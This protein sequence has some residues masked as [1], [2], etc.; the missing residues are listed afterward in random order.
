MIFV[1]FQRLI[2]FN[3]IG[4][5]S[6]SI[7]M[8]WYDIVQTPSL[9]PDSTYLN[10]SLCVGVVGGVWPSS[11]PPPV[12]WELI[13]SSNINI[14]AFLGSSL[15]NIILALNGCKRRHKSLNSRRSL[16]YSPSNACFK[17]V[18]AEIEDKL[19]LI[20]SLN[21]TMSRL[22]NTTFLINFDKR[23][24]W[25]TAY[26]TQYRLCQCQTKIR[27][28]TIIIISWVEDCEDIKDV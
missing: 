25:D 8:T 7:F 14:P 27:K 1:F 26:S 28:I 24:E 11:R 21:N 12:V 3:T 17:N 9:H 23:T 20:Y 4:T 5:F 18:L 2:F 19:N 22:V 16:G 10:A 6:F 13:Y 15:D